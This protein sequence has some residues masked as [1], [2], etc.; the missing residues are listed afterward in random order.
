MIN[1][2]HLEYDWSG[3]LRYFIEV[4]GQSLEQDTLMVSVMNGLRPG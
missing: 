4:D 3:I 1:S 2:R